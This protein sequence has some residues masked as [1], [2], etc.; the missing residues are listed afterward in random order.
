MGKSGNPAKQALN[1]AARQDLL[2]QKQIARQR[3]IIDRLLETN[4]WY[5]RMLEELR[6]TKDWDAAIMEKFITDGLAKVEEI[7]AKYREKGIV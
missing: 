1:E 6:D 3:L 7:N 2:R 4:Q 5:L